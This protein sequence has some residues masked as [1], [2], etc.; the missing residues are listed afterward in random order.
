MLACLSEDE[1]LCFVEGRLAAARVPALEAHARA[2]LTCEQ[3]LAAAM[4][5]GSV[6]G[7]HSSEDHRS[8]LAT[9][10]DASSGLAR[11]ALMGRYTVLS[12]VGRGGMGEVYAA[13]DPQLDR[14]V[15]LKL[16]RPRYALGN[17]RAEAR[18][19]REARAIARLSHPNVIAVYDAGTVGDQIFVAMEYVDGETLAGW[20]TAK[21][22]TQREILD[23]FLGAAHGL[24]AAHASGLVHRDFKP[25]NVMV[26]RDGTARVTDFGLVQR[27]NAD[28]ENDLGEAGPER[29]GDT[30]N[31]TLTRPGEL[32][33]TP[34][35]M[36]PEQFKLAPTDARTDQFS[37]CVTLYQA[38]YGEHPF[39]TDAKAGL[40]RLREDVIAG[41]IRAPAG[42]DTVPSWLRRLLQRGLATDPEARWPSMTDLAAELERRVRPGRE[43]DPAVGSRERMFVCAG[44]SVLGVVGVVVLDVLRRST[45]TAETT[46]LLVTPSIALTLHALV[47][48]VWRKRLLGNQFARNVAAMAWLGGITVILHRLM[49]FRFGVPVPYVLAVDLL[50]LGLEQIIAAVLF[51]AWFAIGALFFFGGAGV[52]MLAPQQALHA[53]LGAV[54]AAYATVGVLAASDHASAT[55]T[56]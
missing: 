35:Y 19:L 26:A 21:P 12:L 38:L 20:L 13:Y 1:V 24:A 28:E 52:V 33:G 22:R 48:W 44:L 31:L 15:A 45:H 25:H 43:R 10:P 7:S 36:S 14:R 17:A 46:R 3:L 8:F 53:M 39:L 34:L 32:L 5:A 23:V 16:L 18:L 11:G 29:D 37:F 54:I 2:C 30:M 41:K 50:V 42:R 40:G 27:L 49:A 56:R 9:S 4:A 6:T 51:K 47:A 55:S